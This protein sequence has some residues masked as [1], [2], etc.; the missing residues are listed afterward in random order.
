MLEIRHEAGN[1]QYG[2]RSCISAAFALED[3]F[4]GRRG[5]MLVPLVDHL[6]PG[7]SYDLTAVIVQRN[8]ISSDD[9][10]AEVQQKDGHSES[11]IGAL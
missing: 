8:Q 4:N 6:E 9:F 2:W 10:E 1:R 3:V 7:D 11:S 5:I